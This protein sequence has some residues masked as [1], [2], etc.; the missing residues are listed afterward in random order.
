MGFIRQVSTVSG[1]LNFVV[2]PACAADA[3]STDSAATL[4]KSTVRTAITH[5]LEHCVCSLRGIRT[6]WRLPGC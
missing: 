3:L 5:N 2:G 1:H 4:V 6:R